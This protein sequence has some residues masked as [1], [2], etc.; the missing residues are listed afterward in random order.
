MRS[1]WRYEKTELLRGQNEASHD[2][3]ARGT[4]GETLVWDGM[5][6]RI[7]AALAPTE[8]TWVRCKACDET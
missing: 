1:V 7:V 5:H 3:E 6:H 4:L 2:T 8:G